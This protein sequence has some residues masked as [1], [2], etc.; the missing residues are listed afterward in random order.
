MDTNEADTHR[1][2]QQIDQGKIQLIGKERRRDSVKNEIT[3][4]RQDLARRELEL[5]KI[6]I[7]I[8]ALRQAAEHDAHQLLE[9]ER[10]RRNI[11]WKKR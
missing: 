5:K 2:R 11:M 9:L 1:L 7:E 3:R 4:A 6:E 10:Q 8:M